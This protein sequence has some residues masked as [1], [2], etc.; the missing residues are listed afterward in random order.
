MNTGNDLHVT[1]LRLLFS[2]CN[3]TTT[4]FPT[5]CTSNNTQ[6]D[7]ERLLEAWH[8]D[9]VELYIDYLVIVGIIIISRCAAYVALRLMPP[10]RTTAA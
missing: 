7:G 3:T 9:F 10:Y 4:L 5:S 2:R 1:G 6:I 8:L